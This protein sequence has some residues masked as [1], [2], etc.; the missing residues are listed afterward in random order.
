MNKIRRARSTLQLA[1]IPGLSGRFFSTARHVSWG[2]GLRPGIGVLLLLAGVSPSY[3]ESITMT[4]DPVGDWVC[5]AGHCGSSDTTRTVNVGLLSGSTAPV[6]TLELRISIT[7]GGEFSNATVSF[8]FDFDTDVTSARISSSSGN[9]GSGPFSLASLPNAHVEFNC[10][11]GPCTVDLMVEFAAMPTS[12]DIRDNVN[13]FVDSPGAPSQTLTATFST[14]PAAK[15]VPD[16]TNDGVA[17]IALLRHGSVSV[18]LRDGGTGALLDAGE[19]IG[20]PFASVDLVVI[21]DVS[22][23]GLAEIGALGHSA[24]GMIKLRVADANTGT[25]ISKFNFYT[26]GRNPVAITAIA[27][28]SGNALADVALLVERQSD[29]RIFVRVF[30]VQTGQQ[31]GGDIEFL[32]AGFRARDMVILPDLD[33]NGVEE[34]GVYATRRSD[35][36]PVVEIR[37]ADGTGSFQRVFFLQSGFKALGIR[38]APDQDNNGV[39]DLAVHGLR[40][41]DR[42]ILIERKNATGDSNR[43]RM[44]FFNAPQPKFH[45]TGSFVALP[46][47]TGDTDT[48]FA[49]LGVRISDQKPSLETKDA[50][51]PANA[52]RMFPFNETF[53]AR[54]V[55]DLG[56]LNGNGIPDL[57]IIAIRNS[58]QRIKMELRDARGP[59]NTRTIAFEP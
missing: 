21:P 27:D 58:D 47:A 4:P 39:P 57:G 49:V 10:R 46:D 55:I 16:I 9:F 5:L 30:D 32:D 23:N 53:E 50:V 20:D 34:I 40:L 51:R 56:D 52:N 24:A 59:A 19:Y 18:E 6:P 48:E 38:L 17:E 8:P 14:V 54:A 41:S 11:Q 15:P 26:S 13:Q 12:V 35:G 2:Y 25:Q 29:N 7:D 36:R 45:P 22:G 43:T 1:A 3:A 31:S 28:V 37:E 44:W 33:S 42:R